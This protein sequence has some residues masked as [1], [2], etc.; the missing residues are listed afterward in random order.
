MFSSNLAPFIVLSGPQ[1]LSDELLCFV[2]FKV[3]PLQLYWYLKHLIV[4]PEIMVNKM[5]ARGQK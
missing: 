5:A 2:N 1:P 3:L 4:I